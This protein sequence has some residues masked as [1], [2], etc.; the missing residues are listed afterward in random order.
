MDYIIEWC[1]PMGGQE[2]NF[3]AAAGKL[4]TQQISA[5]EKLLSRPLEIMLARSD[6]RE[7]GEKREQSLK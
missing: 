3:L 1:Y 2:D 6:R 5:L 4:C 7:E